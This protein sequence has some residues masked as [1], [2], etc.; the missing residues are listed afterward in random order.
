MEALRL[1]R[2]VLEPQESREGAGGNGEQDLVRR[3][4][5]RLLEAGDELIRR[6]LTGDSE[7]FLHDHRQMGG[8]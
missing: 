1:R 2:P 8:Q 6:S 3:E 5:R 4:A 7:Q